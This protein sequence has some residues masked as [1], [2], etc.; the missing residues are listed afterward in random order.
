MQEVVDEL[1]QQLTST[2]FKNRLVVILAGY[3]NDMSDLMNVNEGLKSRFSET[4]LFEDFSLESVVTLLTLN[5]RK[6]GLAELS[7]NAIAAIP[8][9]S[10][11]L[12]AAPGFGNG[13]DVETLTKRIIRAFAS[14]SAA[15][16]DETGGGNLMIDTCDLDNA[17]RQFIKEKWQSSSANATRSS[18]SQQPLQ[19]PA[20]M[21]DAR[22]ISTSLAPG[23]QRTLQRQA[24]SS[25]DIKTDDSERM[26]ISGAEVAS[27]MSDVSPDPF[28]VE[29]QKSIDDMGLNSELGVEKLASLELDSEDFQRL[30][31]ELVRRTGLAPDEA[32]DKL[33]SWRAAQADVRAKMK[34]QEKETN[35]AKMEKRRALLPIWRCGVCGRANKPYIACYVQPYIVEYRECDV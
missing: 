32:R 24:V 11:E 9:L 16:N 17:F 23:A 19:Q 31:D 18:I 6:E 4:I 35:L 1:V 29:M 14:R 5:I 22:P 28:L 27:F 2:E 10:Q 33:I 15:V 3:K 12:M 25:K 13:R 8:H 7:D 21:E 20:L 30:V 26:E 34:E